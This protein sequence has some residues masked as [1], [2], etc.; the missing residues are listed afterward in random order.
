MIP[1][2]LKKIIQVKKCN[3]N[4]C[5]KLYMLSIRLYTTK[6]PTHFDIQTTL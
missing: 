6:K 3:L 5:K 2:D 4:A 1:L